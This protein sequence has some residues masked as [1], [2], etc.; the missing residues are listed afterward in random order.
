MP[1]TEKPVLAILA[2]V[3][4]TSLMTLASAQP[5]QAW[6]GLPLPPQMTPHS[7]PAIIGDRPPVPAVVPAGEAQFDE[8]RG[9]Q[10]LRDL[11]DIIDFS[12]RS[13]ES[14]ELG[15]S[16]MWGRVSGFPSAEQTVDWVVDGIRDAGIEDIRVQVLT[17][18]E[19]AVLW[20][21][22]QW[23]VRLH[24]NT[25]FGP[26]TDDVILSTAMPLAPSHISGGALTAPVVYV[27]TGSPAELAHINVQGK[28]AVQRVTPQGHLVFERGT[29][30]PRANDLMARG[31]LAVLNIVDL[32]G[33][34]M[35]RDFSNCGGP[36]FN[37]GGRDGRFL[38]GV[39][40]RAAQ[41]GV[42]DEVTMTLSLQARE[43]RGLQ[44]RNAIAVIPGSRAETIVL[45]AHY[46][47]WFDGAGDNADGL[48]VLMAMAR[49]FARA[50]VT[51]ERTLVLVASAGHHTP[52]LHGP[53]QAVAM[54]P[55][56]F[57]NSVLTFNIEHVA[58]RNF[59][60]ASSVSE[61][62]YREFIADSVEAPIVAGITNQAPFLRALI[63][64]GVQRYG[65][66]FV[67]GPSTMASGEGSGYSNLGV[68]VVTAMQASPL[69]H[70][71]GEVFEVVSE[72]GLERMARFMRHFV[73]QVDQATADQLNP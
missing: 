48:A 5:S 16:Q 10:L 59:S 65:V 54:N 66:N 17:Q 39:M 73:I 47:A 26:G 71:T 15:G 7:L 45:N 25:A 42:L 56:L 14:R 46:D 69:Y 34:E 1:L 62:G 68:P 58:Q 28:I 19:N 22:E 64:E 2:I 51:L 20:M 21:P 72:P 23:E 6:F 57:G 27:G 40:N 55:D 67:S 13:R 60:P 38:E 53:R 18:D 11:R 43:H 50:E 44:A 9:A 4:T 41:S 30:V 70:T 29:V 36:C 61:D 63:D 33:N 24:G 12:V 3:L 35:A 37:L 49:H 52:G 8:L 32:P 31:A